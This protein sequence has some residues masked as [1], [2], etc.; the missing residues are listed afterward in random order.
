MNCRNVQSKLSEYV[1]QELSGQEMMAI[2]QH[3]DRCP[4]CASELEREVKLKSMLSSLKGLEPVA[5]FESRLIGAVLSSA[6]APARPVALPWRNLMLAAAAGAA[7]VLGVLRTID[8]TPT[9]NLAQTPS[10]ID[11]ATDQ[12]VQGSQDPFGGG[13]VITVSN[14]G[15]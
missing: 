2:R 4:I 5:G 9:T 11:L 3:S 1:D 13:P 12:A 15:R 14:G 8:H 7:L 6:E 10:S